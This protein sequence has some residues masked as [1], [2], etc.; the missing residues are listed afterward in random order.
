M[1]TRRA[2]LTTAPLAA[3]APTALLAETAPAPPPFQI[4]TAEKLAEAAHTLDAAPGNDS[5][6]NSPTLP[7][8]IVLS[9]EEK[10][11]AKEFEWHEGRDHIFQVLEGSTTYELGGTPQSPRNTRPGEWLAPAST[12]ATTLNLHKGDLLVIPRNTPHK[13]STESS[14]TFYLISTEGHR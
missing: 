12:G 13:R 7:F 4:F 5:L 10:K 11:S 14:V 3:L 9:V 1:T 6:F 8:T 2:F